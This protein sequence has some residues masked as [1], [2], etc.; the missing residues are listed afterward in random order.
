MYTLFK[1]TEDNK[2]Y[3]VRRYTDYIV[4]RMDNIQLLEEFKNYFYREKIGYPC[5]TLENEINRYCPE[6][7]EDHVVENVVGRGPEFFNKSF[8]KEAYHV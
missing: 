4:T 5:E 6:I 8:N 1:I 2:P 3:T 7:L